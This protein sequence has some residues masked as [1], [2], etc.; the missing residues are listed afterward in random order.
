MKGPRTWSKNDG[1]S[2]G[3]SPSMLCLLMA[4]QPDFP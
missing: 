2:K 1:V 3:A 4:D